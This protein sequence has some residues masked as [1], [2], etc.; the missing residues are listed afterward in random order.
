[1]TFNNLAHGSPYAALTGSISDN[2]T[3]DN[4]NNQE[5][6]NTC[7]VSSNNVNNGWKHK[8]TKAGTLLWD[9]ENAEGDVPDAAAVR[10]RVEG[11]GAKGRMGCS[12][13]GDGGGDA[14]VGK[15][16]QGYRMQVRQL[17]L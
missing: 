16:S 14:D 5:N 1:M 12:D 2:T 9:A 13:D 6:N 3:H 11:I 8:H 17:V 4:K 10:H 15:P 7:S